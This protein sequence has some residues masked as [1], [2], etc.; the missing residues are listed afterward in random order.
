M[1]VLR[2]RDPLHVRTSPAGFA[3]AAQV[4]DIA[5]ELACDVRELDPADVWRSA[6]WL[7]REKPMVAAQVLVALAAFVDVDEPRS[8]RD[9][10]VDAIT[11]VRHGAA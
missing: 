11:E 6:D 9:A 1:N 8:V 7:V 3:T 5:D 2:N 10:R 4:E